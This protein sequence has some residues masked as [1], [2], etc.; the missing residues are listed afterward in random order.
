MIEATP[1][2]ANRLPLICSE[3]DILLSKIGPNIT[4]VEAPGSRLELASK[5]VLLI[6]GAGFLGTSIAL[7]LA[8]LGAAPLVVAVYT[9]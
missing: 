8:Q 2:P 1:R 9:Y 4:A 5:R 7:K 6:G 3:A